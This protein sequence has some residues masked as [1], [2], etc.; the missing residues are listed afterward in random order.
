[1]VTVVACTVGLTVPAGA[2]VDL[3]PSSAGLGRETVFVV[4]VEGGCDGAP[5]TGIAVAMPEGVWEARV[6]DVPG[7]TST[8][9]MEPL[10]EPVVDAWRVE[11]TARVGS[12]TWSATPGAAIVDD[13]FADFEVLAKVP[14]VEAG[15]VLSFPVEQR[16]S[17]Q[18]ISWDQPSAAGQPVPDRPAPA[19]VVT[20]EG[21][22]VVPGS[23]EVAEGDEAV[24]AEADD[25]EEG[26]AGAGLAWISLG[27][28]L[29]ALSGAA[30]ALRRPT[31]PSRQ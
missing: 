29:A 24:A 15:T 21:G 18:A 8:V 5:T 16:C 25:E 31:A 2:E 11:R 6:K 22:G 14:V 13:A 20:G 17:D 23:P 30:V 1:M 4:R 3:E 12:V 28:A 19:L 26:S 7:W 27:V 9:T 10:P